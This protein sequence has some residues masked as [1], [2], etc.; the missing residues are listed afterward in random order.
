MKQV[1]RLT[2]SDLHNIIRE[3][4]RNVLKED[5]AMGGDAATPGATSASAD[6]VGA[7]DVP[8][9]GVQRR[10]VYNPSNSESR[11]AKCCPN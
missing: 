5:G 6:R 4:V 11:W 2:E 10:D 1:I 9:G 7:F 8:F 3:A